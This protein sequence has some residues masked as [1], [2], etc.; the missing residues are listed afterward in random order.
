MRT[1]ISLFARFAKI[2]SSLFPFC[3]AKKSATGR[4]SF[5]NAISPLFFFSVYKF[6]VAGELSGFYTKS[7]SDSAFLGLRTSAHVS[8][9]NAR[10][11]TTP[12]NVPKNV[13]TVKAYRN[14][15]TPIAYRFVSDFNVQAVFQFF[16]PQALVTSTI[17]ANPNSFIL[18]RHT[19]IS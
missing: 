4:R 19:L 6:W 3:F 11:S 7:K 12:V 17:T 15:A 5:S 14:I 10:V 13:K 16:P 1:R 18:A 9:P 2:S 8:A